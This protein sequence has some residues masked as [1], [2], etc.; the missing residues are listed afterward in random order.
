MSIFSRIFNLFSVS[1]DADI[2]ADASF[3][4]SF[5]YI[6][7][8]LMLTQ[9]LIMGVYSMLE[10]NATL[11][12]MNMLFS[13]SFITYFVASYIVRR[14]SIVEGLDMMAIFLYFLA[15][16]FTAPLVGLPGLPVMLYPFIAI[17]LHGR[18]KGVWLS[19][20]QVVIISVLAVIWF[21]IADGEIFFGYTKRQTV[22]TCIV[23]TISTFVYYIA[24]RWLSGLV[25]DKNREIAIISEELKVK[26][27]LVGKL[28]SGVGKHIDDIKKAASILNTERLNPLQNELVGLVRAAAQ[29]AANS[30]N[31]VIKAATHN[32]P[33]VPEEEVRFNLYTLLSNMLKLFKSKNPNKKHSFSVASDVPEVLLGNSIMTR[34][35]LLNILDALEDK[36][37]LA[38]H[39]MKIAVTHDDIF[40][41]GVV[42]HF[43]ITVGTELQTDSRDVTNGESKVTEHL[44]LDVTKR[45][46]ESEQCSFIASS[47]NGELRI[48]FSLRYNDGDV[49]T[50]SDPDLLEKLPL[51]L[52]AT[53]MLGEATVLV[54]SRNEVKRKEIGGLVSTMVKTVKYSSSTDEA[55]AIFSNSKIDLIMVDGSDGIEGGAEF[56]MRI[57]NSESEITSR[58]P[59]VCVLDPLKEAK[60][61]NICT[62]AG[63]D[64]SVPYPLDK[65]I[66]RA[67]INSYFF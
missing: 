22:T 50:T 35:V 16:F 61:E 29:N 52:Q 53:E 32:I 1:A 36:V 3:R 20:S 17:I 5:S 59:M 12:T 19:I 41:K 14:S 21:G 49:R 25:Y 7:N 4:Q 26:N 2:S 40:E 24:V 46:V 13:L 23:M 48:E 56:V 18:E 15:I 45:I 43:T 27:E 63:F 65:E 39:D 9:S 30:V 55:C 6:V 28:T 67:V 11:A 33:I 44:E 54:L 34:Q 51:P 38:E 42:L 57:R 47:S 8:F 62:N 31:A 10:E 66:T 58:V 64:S 60:P 37:G